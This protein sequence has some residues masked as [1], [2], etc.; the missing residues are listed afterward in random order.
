MEVYLNSKNSIYKYNIIYDEFIHK[1]QKIKKHF[2][3][4]NREL[5]EVTSNSNEIGKINIKNMNL[6]KNVKKLAKY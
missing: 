5:F 4:K 6:E 2:N 1:I 3:I